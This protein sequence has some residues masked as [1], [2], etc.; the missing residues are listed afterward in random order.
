M[1][2]RVFTFLAVCFLAISIRAETNELFALGY[3]QYQNG[4][5]TLKT[6][7]EVWSKSPTPHTESEVQEFADWEKAAYTV[8]EDLWNPTNLTR[9]GDFE[10]E[11]FE[12]WYKGSPYLIAQGELNVSVVADTNTFESLATGRIRLDDDTIANKLTKQTIKNFNP[13]TDVA[14]GK[15]IILTAERKAALLAFLGDDSY[16]A[17]TGNI[18]SPA[19]AKGESRRRAAFIHNSLPI[20]HGHWGGWNLVTYPEVLEI[21]LNS[22]T[23]RAA[24]F[25]RVG[26]RGGTALYEQDNKCKWS[27]KKSMATWIQ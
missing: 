7:F 12:N 8:F 22:D 1:K 11:D 5:A 25:F 3:Q 15:T 4:L 23:T 20:D 19:R 21:I 10:A 9:L 2:S 17:G 26:Y 14:N 13:R 24:V 18:M 16:P 27:L 6:V